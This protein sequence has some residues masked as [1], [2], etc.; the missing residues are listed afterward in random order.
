MEIFDLPIKPV[1]GSGS[2]YRKTDPD[3]HPS[4][5]QD[6]HPHQSQKADSTPHHS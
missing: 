2:E 4:E 5:K 1:F 6:P 3:P